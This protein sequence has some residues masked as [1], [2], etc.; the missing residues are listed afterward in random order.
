[1]SRRLAISLIV[2]LTALVTAGPALAA[3]SHPAIR[4]VKGVTHDQDFENWVNGVHA[5]RADYCAT[6]VPH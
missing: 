3:K 1:V 5:A 4:T 2:G 6:G